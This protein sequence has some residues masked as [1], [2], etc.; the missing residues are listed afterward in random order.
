MPSRQ[1]NAGLAIG[2][3][4]GLQVAAVLVEQGLVTT[5]HRSWLM[6]LQVASGITALALLW[7]RSRQ[8]QVGAPVDHLEAP[9]R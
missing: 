6:G 1:F 9:G 2:L 4:I 3:G 5:Q 8:P 7:P